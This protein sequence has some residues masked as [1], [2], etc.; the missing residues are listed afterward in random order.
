MCRSLPLLIVLPMFHLQA[1][2]Q[3]YPVETV[4]QTG[5]Y[6][7][8]SSV[9]FSPGGKFAATGS[10]DKTIKLWETASGR[11]IRSFQGSAGNV[12]TLAFG[13]S[14]RLLASIDQD[15]TVKIWEVPTSRLLHEINAVGPHSLWG[16]AR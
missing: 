3:D 5:H 8:V 15:Y 13:P 11:E 2:P 10:S 16:F 14:S 4:I 6:A 1:F 12:R 7:A 9:A